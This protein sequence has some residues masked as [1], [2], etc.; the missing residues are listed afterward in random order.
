MDASESLNQW[1]L[2]RPT[3]IVIDDSQASSESTA[4]FS[5]AV[6]EKAYRPCVMVVDDRLTESMLH[7]LPR[8]LEL[9]GDQP[10]GK[11]R[12]SWEDFKDN[13]KDSKTICHESDVGTVW[14]FFVYIIQAIGKVWGMKIKDQDQVPARPLNIIMDKTISKDGED[15]ID[16]EWKTDTA[17]SHHLESL[18]S[19][20]E[21]PW[22]GYD[23]GFL[24]SDGL[25]IIIKV[26]GLF[27]IYCLGI[28]LK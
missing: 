16:A 1:I 19:V 25:S 15:V 5:T 23:G 11:I 24:G 20:A 6:F 22:L 7:D 14:N 12:T 17:L 27:H 8:L 2:S 21:R 28:V 4:G 26:S 10:I 18:Y 9:R 3:W 13:I